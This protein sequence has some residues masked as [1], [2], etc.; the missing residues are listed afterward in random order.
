M[1]LSCADDKL[2]AYKSN[3]I[4]IMHYAKE[5]EQF[6]NELL[7]TDLYLLGLSILLKLSF[8]T[9]F[10]INYLALTTFSL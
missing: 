4:P 8:L 2:Y 5:N 7:Y 6:M 3:L 10:I 1:L 9:L